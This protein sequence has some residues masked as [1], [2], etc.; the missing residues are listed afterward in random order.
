MKPSL[1][2][3]IHAL[4]FTTGETWK[5][6]ELMRTFSVSIEEIE[7]A[8]SDLKFDME[9]Q[10]VI[11]LVYEQTITLITR[12]ELKDF[13][14]SLDDAE[15][16]KEF[17]KGAIETLALVAYKGPISKSDID[18]I[19]GVNSQ[20]MLRNLVMRGMVEKQS[21][22]KDRSAGYVIT[23]DALRFLGIEHYNQLPHFD[24]FYEEISKR[25]PDVSNTELSESAE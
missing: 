20:F 23:V 24:N 12:P 1:S 2:Q 9:H 13:L 16:I 6:S 10:A 19:R 22:S 4:L 7:T 11:P 8:L 17:S 5:F 18:Y 21:I 3:S 14:Q 15:S 25:I